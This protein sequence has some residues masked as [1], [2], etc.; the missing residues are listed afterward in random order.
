MN[1][2]K[3]DLPVAK[4]RFSLVS[5]ALFIAAILMGLFQLAHS[6]VSFAAEMVNIAENLA[7]RGS[8]SNPFLVL[9]T[10]Y[11]AANPPLY[12]MFLAVLWKVFKTRD[13]VAAAAA[14][15]NILVNAFTALLLPRVASLLFG[16]KTPGV[17]ASILWILS[18]QLLPSWDVDY[19]VAGLLLFCLCAASIQTESGNS[20]RDSFFAGILAGLLFL[21]NPSTLLISVPWI[22]FL[23]LRHKL[24]LRNTAIPLAILFLMMF[25]W[26]AR[27]H[28]RLGAYVVR[29]NLGFTLYASDND[30]AES[31]LI[32]D[33]ESGCYGAH[34]PNESISE[35]GLM[36]SLG[37]VRFDRLRVAATEAWIKSHPARFRALTIERFWDF[38]FPPLLLAY[39]HPHPYLVCMIW[40]ITALSIPGL[41]LMIYRREAVAWYILAVLF[42]YPLMYYLVV[43]DIRYRDP[44]L[45][46]SLL[47]VGYLIWQW[48]PGNWHVAPAGGVKDRAQLV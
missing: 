2:P 48:L 18:M 36:R 9:N 40:A 41:I 19:T 33:R 7:F 44:V 3:K 15:C 17:I 11:T 12:P 43:S 26:I 22:A 47:P 30:C 23:L 4:K 6:H 8:F 46:L 32:A 45:W 16:E 10:G 28:H 20:L 34:H 14:L 1:T 13:A 37:E 24:A 5:L 38:W 31:S 27:N 39:P 25:A 42:I 21:L 29:T 35:A